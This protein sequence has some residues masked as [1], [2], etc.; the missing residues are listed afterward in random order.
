MLAIVASER[1]L[2]GVEGLTLELWRRE[3]RI[4]VNRRAADM[5]MCFIGEYSRV[6]YTGA[7][8]SGIS[9]SILSYTYL[10]LH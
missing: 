9:V 6:C 8:G 1:V 5:L 4:D 2:A 7:I 3:F 10:N